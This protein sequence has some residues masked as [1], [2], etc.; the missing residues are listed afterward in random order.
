M[1]VALAKILSRSLVGLEEFRAVN[2][3]LASVINDRPL[4]YV[5][6]ESG[7][8]SVLTAANLRI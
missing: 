3:E 6:A 2:A 8:P 5:A 1:K 4:T 7:A